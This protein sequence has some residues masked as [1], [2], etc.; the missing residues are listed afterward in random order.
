MTRALI[1]TTISLLI[2]FILLNDISHAHPPWG[3]AVD[4][5]RRVYFSAL[6]TIWKIDAEGRL[7]VFRAGVSGRH[8]HELRMDEGG[9]LYGEDLTYEPATGRWISALWKMTPAG[10]FAYLLAPTDK[11]PKGLSIWTDSRGNSYS[12]QRETPAHELLL[13]KRTPDGNLEALLGSKAALEKRRQ[14]LF[15]NLGGAAFGAEGAFYFT[16]GR[17]VRKLSA[18]GSIKLLARE[19]ADAHLLGLTVDARGDVYVADLKSRRVL[20][21]NADGKAS[22]VLEAER[23]WMP[24]GVAHK[25]GSLYILE[26]K[27]TPAA[28]SLVPRVRRLSADGKV[29]VLA[30]V[31][32]SRSIARPEETMRGEKMEAVAPSREKVSYTL[33]GAGALVLACA[34]VAWER[35]RRRVG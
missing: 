2:T 27:S 12:L 18:D 4:T 22:A 13:T 20:K 31:G 26:F 30:T 28:G 3:I 32:E 25:D 9:N 29:T 10:D 16:D 8:T 24:T 35:A 21:I 33:I 19:V 7:A 11:P 6:E 34:F 14:T 23:E 15:Y 5:Q 17:S 1:N